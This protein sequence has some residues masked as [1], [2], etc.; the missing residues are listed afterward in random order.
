MRSPIGHF[1]P[2]TVHRINSPSQRS[3]TPSYR[4]PSIDMVGLM[5]DGFTPIVNFRPPYFPLTVTPN[6]YSPNWG[7][8]P[9][10][11][12]PVSPARVRGRYSRSFRYPDSGANPPLSTSSPTPL[13][14][15]QYR[16]QN[17]L[18]NGYFPSAPLQ[19]IIPGEHGSMVLK[20]KQA[21]QKNQTSI[22]TD[23][24]GKGGVYER[25]LISRG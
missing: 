25:K 2:D 17:Y 6:R 5:D 3:H 23:S 11:F 22:S 19:R 24:I 18:R 13:S 14:E 20:C 21:V 9:T 15:D 12:V 4:V 1:S 7:N 16:R 10:S 8:E